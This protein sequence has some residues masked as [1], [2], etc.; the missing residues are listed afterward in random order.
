V[1]VNVTDVDRQPDGV[2]CCI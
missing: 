2:R 1:G